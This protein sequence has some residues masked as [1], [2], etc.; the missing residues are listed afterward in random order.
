MENHH[1][2]HHTHVHSPEGGKNIAIAFLLNFSFT[3]IELVGGLLT[4]SVAILSDALHDLGDSISLA[5]AWYFQKV[6]GYSPSARYSYGYKRFA[7]LG[8]LI[9]ATVL[10]LGSVFVIYASVMRIL[11]PQY[12]KVEGM[13]LLAI[14]GVIINGV[15]VWRTHKSSGINERIVSLHLLEDVLGWI[16][17]L[18]ASVVMMFVEVPIL[19]P[20]LS[21]GISIFVLYNVVRNLIATFNVILQ[22]VP[23]DIKLIELQKK[24]E[25]LE[26]VIS[27]HDLHVWSLDSQY[28][29]ASLHAVISP[30]MTLDQMAQ[31]K[32]K[33]KLL[34]LAEQI[35]HTTVEFETE[36]EECHP[37]DARL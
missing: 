23:S 32:Q 36:Q 17:V 4:N 26:A 3:I 10:L 9:N 12:V 37:C 29:I 7:L 15:A 25:Q 19:D 34:M 2:H 33:I 21:I 5:L 28:N 24:V 31:L 16:A 14:L 35:E 11:Q 13:F 1:S 6:S 18:I 27:V 20:I 8:A 30:E 22:G